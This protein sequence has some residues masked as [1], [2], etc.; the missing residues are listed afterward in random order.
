[1]AHTPG[2]YGVYGKPDGKTLEVAQRETHKIIASISLRDRNAFDNA[3]L[4]AASPEMLDAL[5]AL[6]DG[7]ATYVSNTIVITCNSHADA[8]QRMRKAREAVARATGR[9]TTQED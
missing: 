2:P 1:M 7:D 9:T 4:F 3:T 6:T 5:R 8:V